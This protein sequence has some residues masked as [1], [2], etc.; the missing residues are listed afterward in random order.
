M[1]GEPLELVLD[2]PSAIRAN[3]PQ[4]LRKLLPMDLLA[5]QATTL[6]AAQTTGCRFVQ[7]IDL[8]QIHIMVG[9]I[10]ST[11]PRINPQHTVGEPLG[12][13]HEQHRRTVGG[14]HA[15]PT[16]IPGPGEQRR[17]RSVTT[18]VFVVGP[19]GRQLPDEGLRSR[20]QM[21]GRKAAIGQRRPGGVIGDGPVGIGRGRWR[22]QCCWWRCG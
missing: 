6:T 9:R 15:L 11:I 3:L 8:T 5:A 17:D 21:A 22:G 18:A 14:H 16:G 4:I 7:P 12:K 19:I 20:R 10:P 13:K 2:L 1:G